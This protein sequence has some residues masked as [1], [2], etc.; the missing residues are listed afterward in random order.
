MDYSVSEA[1]SG[2]PGLID[3]AQAGERVV[4][5]RHGEPVAELRPALPGASTTRDSGLARLGER[6][7]SRARITVR[8][9]DILKQ[10]SEE[11]R[12]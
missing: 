8:S 10:I 6:R 7:R 11:G 4:I 2:L 5:T 9:L 12:W 3:R 1:R